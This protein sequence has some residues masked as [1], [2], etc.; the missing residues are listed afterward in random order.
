MNTRDGRDHRTWTAHG[1]LLRTGAILLALLACIGW[2]LSTV[3]SRADDVTTLRAADWQWAPAASYDASSPPA[4]GWQPY[5]PETV[6]PATAYW[7]RMPLPTAELQDPQLKVYYV[8]SLRAFD[9]ENELF[10]YVLTKKVNWMNIGYHWKMVPLPSPMPAYVDLLVRY[11]EHLPVSAEAELGNKSGL[12]AQMLRED[13]DNLLLGALLLFSGFISLGLYA[14]QRNRLYIYFSLLAFFGGYAAFVRNHLLQAIID[15]PALG[16]FQDVCMP[17][18]TFAFIGAMQQVFPDVHRRAIRLLLLVTLAIASI[19]V[20]GVFFNPWLYG[21]GMFV[22]TPTFLVVFAAS[23]WTIWVAYRRRKDLESVWIMAGFSLLAGIAL[24]HMYRFVVFSFM[25]DSVQRLTSAVLRLPKDLLFWGLFA[26]VVCLIRVIMYRYTGMNRQLIEFNRS[27]EHAVHVRTQELEERT[28]QLERTHERLAASM[29]ENAEALAETMIMEE[30][31]RITGSIHE[32]VGHTLSD[33]IVRLAD[34]KRLLPDDRE[35]AEEKLASSQ[36]L[37]RRGLEDIR[38]SVRL[39]REDA[40]H[41][42][43]HGAIG[44]LIRETTLTA[45]CAIDKRLGMLPEQLGTA[46]KRLLFQTVREGIGSGLKLERPVRSF[47]LSIWHE[48]SEGVVRLELSYMNANKP[49][50]ASDWTIGL[51]SLAEQANRLSGELLAEE[52]GDECRIRLSVPMTTHA[53]A[54]SRIV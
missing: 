40:G 29:R 35:Q 41:F 39:L 53:S 33:T 22:F 48:E 24:L 49:A 4:N 8:G 52:A 17:I 54:A 51:R 32:T 46:H 25:P 37:L 36:D 11:K 15:V 31:H 6:V 7:L 18:A 5:R 28:G 42:D 50:N 14:S 21:A 45:G 27:L 23:Y 19:T 26:F 10:S 12:I 1:P 20:I 30:R 43:L 9:G 47:E 38:Q 2:L 13:L 3:Q 34:A 16:Y 44:A